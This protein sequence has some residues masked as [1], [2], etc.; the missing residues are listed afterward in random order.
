ML[1]S[2]YS[3]H[4]QS[5]DFKRESTREESIHSICRN[6]G[7][8]SKKSDVTPLFWSVFIY[9]LNSPEDVLLSHPLWAQDCFTVEWLVVRP[10]DLLGFASQLWHHCMP[11]ASCSPLSTSPISSWEWLGAELCP[12]RP[13]P[14]PTQICTWKPLPPAPQNLTVFGNEAFQEVTGLK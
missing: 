2:N 13:P 9:F 8:G 1:A 12:P 4:A 5:S 11:L 10:V 6:T 3:L 14:P 7:P